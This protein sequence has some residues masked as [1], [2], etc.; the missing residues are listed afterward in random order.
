MEEQASTNFSRGTAAQG[1][2]RAN[3]FLAAIRDAVEAR[4]RPQTFPDPTLGAC[5]DQ[6]DQIDRRVGKALTRQCRLYNKVARCPRRRSYK[7]VADRVGKIATRSLGPME[8]RRR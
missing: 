5:S 2:I 3:R 6:T 8:G 7:K 4:E 1:S